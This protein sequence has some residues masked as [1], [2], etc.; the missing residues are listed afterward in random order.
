MVRAAGLFA[1]SIFSALATI[2]APALASVVN[3]ASLE[4][5]APLSQVFL[6]QGASVVTKGDRAACVVF[7]AINVRASRYISPDRL[8]VPFDE[9]ER[10]PAAGI[11]A[12]RLVRAS[13]TGKAG[14]TSTPIELRVT[15][16]Y[17]VATLAISLDSETIAESIAQTIDLT[18]ALDPAGDSATLSQEVAEKLRRAWA[19]GHEVTLIGQS[20]D[21]GR[22]IE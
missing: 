14:R 7:S 17:P 20:K 4:P 6:T 12:W 21:T 18:R 22:Q 10:S 16:K 19:A 2:T 1:A 11:W 3:S 15:L 8:P 13:S 5:R 9:V